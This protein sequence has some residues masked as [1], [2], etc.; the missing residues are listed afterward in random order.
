M[1]GLLI[2]LICL[3]PA[4]FIM[5][6][7]QGHVQLWLVPVMII[8]VGAWIAV[9]TYADKLDGQYYANAR[10]PMI[11]DTLKADLA[12]C[13]KLRQAIGVIYVVT[14]ILFVLL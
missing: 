8:A 1:D 12:L 10:N 11:A 7:R 14:L 13:A 5:L 4:A 6:I 3:S 9:G 2:F